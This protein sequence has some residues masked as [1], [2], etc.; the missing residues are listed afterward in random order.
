MITPDTGWS[1]TDPNYLADD[2]ENTERPTRSASTI[3]GG[4]VVD[5]P[6]S[7]CGPPAC[8]DKVH[9]NEGTAVKRHVS[10]QASGT[11]P[12]GHS[13]NLL[14]RQ[15]E[16]M[17]ARGRARD[18]RIDRRDRSPVDGGYAAQAAAKWGRKPRSQSRHEQH[19]YDLLSNGYVFIGLT[20]PVHEY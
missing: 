11:S 14:S 16:D 19:M 7:S 9:P 3:G 10:R 12:L 4:H 20:F 2:V 18:S 8:D 5:R 6:S 1:H 13:E 15:A 17:R